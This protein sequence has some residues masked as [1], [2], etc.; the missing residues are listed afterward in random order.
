MEC[1]EDNFYEQYVRELTRVGITSC[2]NLVIT[3]EPDPIGDLAVEDAFWLRV[4]IPSWL[5]KV[6]YICWFGE[7][8]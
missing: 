7:E 6:E 3:N 1:L 5:G 4:I 2:M 8:R